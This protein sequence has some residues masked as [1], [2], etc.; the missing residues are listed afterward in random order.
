ML[1]ECAA[2]R[3]FKENSV[4]ATNKKDDE[5]EEWECFIRIAVAESKRL[6]SLKAVGRLWGREVIQQSKWTSRGLRFCETLRTA[7]RTGSNLPEA[8]IKLNSLKLRRHQIPR[9]RLIEDSANPIS[10]AD[11][12]NL[13]TGAI[14]RLTSRDIVR[15]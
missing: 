3:T 1:D 10:H 11:L 12:E 14:D 4:L 13:L 9:R 15:L 6:T 7:A 8:I 5:T 2:Y